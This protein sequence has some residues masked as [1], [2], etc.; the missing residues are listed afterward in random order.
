MGSCII[1]TRIDEDT[2]QKAERLFY[3]L[4]LDIPTALRMFINQAIMQNKIPF[5]VTRNHSYPNNETLNALREGDKLLEKAKKG[6]AKSFKTVNE[7]FQDL[8][9]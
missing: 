6:E 1:Q 4:G 3:D 7:L 8:E 9:N 5:E 2:K